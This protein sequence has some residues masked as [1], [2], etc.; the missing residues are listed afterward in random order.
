MKLRRQHPYGSCIVD[1][2]CHAARLAIELDG[3]VHALPEQSF[4]VAQLTR[5]LEAEGIRVLRF[6]NHEVLNNTEELLE[7]ISRASACP[8][9]DPLPEGEGISTSVPSADTS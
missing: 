4:H 6:W 3:G 8:H 9:P 7:T 2:H 1:F 5:A